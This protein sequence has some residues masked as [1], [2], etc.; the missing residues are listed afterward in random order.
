L[1]D[2]ME[3]QQAGEGF[4]VPIALSDII[5]IHKEVGSAIFLFIALGDWVTAEFQLDGVRVGSVLGGSKISDK[6]ISDRL[7]NAVPW[8]TIRRWRQHLLGRGLIIQNRVAW[9]YQAAVVGTRKFDREPGTPPDWI[10]KSYK[11]PSVHEPK[12][13]HQTNQKWFIRQTKS[14]SNIIDKTE[15]Q[16]RKT[17]RRSSV[18]SEEAEDLAFDSPALKATWE[19]WERIVSSPGA[20]GLTFPELYQEFDAAEEWAKSKGIARIAR[21]VAF[22]RKWF[23][24]IG[25][26]RVAEQQEPGVDIPLAVLEFDWRAPSGSPAA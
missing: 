20:A 14:G 6:F 9:G 21:P 2:N 10:V 22:M 19:Q 13:V 3:K 18:R 25:K 4:H 8:T 5:E 11:P 7:G 16:N 15:R 23:A 24:R 26:P 1:V 12:V 17:D